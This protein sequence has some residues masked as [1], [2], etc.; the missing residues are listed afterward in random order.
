MTKS[1]ASPYQAAIGSFYAGGKDSAG[2][3]RIR[4]FGGIYS[5][6]LGK[7]SDLNSGLNTGMA[8]SIVTT[9]GKVGKDKTAYEQNLEQMDQQNAGTYDMQK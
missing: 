3:Q 5:Q 1:G 6:I 8:D 2:A 9:P 7:Q 4:K